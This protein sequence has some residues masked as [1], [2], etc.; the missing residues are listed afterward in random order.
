MSA[1]NLE[2]LAREQNLVSKDEPFDVFEAKQNYTQKVKLAGEGPRVCLRCHEMRLNNADERVPYVN[3]M[4]EAHNL[5]EDVRQY[6]QE[7]LDVISTEADTA[8]VYLTCSI[9]EFPANVPVFLRKRRNLK[10]VLTKAEGVVYVPQV[11]SVNVQMWAAAQMQ[12]L[13]F[14]MAAENV[15][16]F[17]AEH[18]K[19]G[20]LHQFSMYD[21][22]RGKN[23]YIVGFPNTGKTSLFNVLTEGKFSKEANDLR[24]SLPKDRR[25][26]QKWKN[27]SWHPE[28][29]LKPCTKKTPFG[30]ITD[31]PAFKRANSPWN[32]V[33]PTNNSYL[34]D[35]MILT[36]NARKFAGVDVHIKRNQVALVSGLFG[37]ESTPASELLVWTSIPGKMG[38]A[39]H[40]NA[41]KANIVCQKG[42]GHDRA[43]YNL[44]DMG[45]KDLPE[46]VELGTVTFDQDDGVGV[47]VAFEGAGFARIK[48]TG[49]KENK[50]KAVIWGFPGQVFA[51]RQPL[52]EL[53]LNNEA[54]VKGFFGLKDPNWKHNRRPIFNYKIDF[55]P[56]R[57]VDQIGGSDSYLYRVKEGSQAHFS[58]EQLMRA[59][60]ADPQKTQAFKLE[61]KL[62]LNNRPRP[63]DGEDSF[64]TPEDLET[65][66]EAREKIR[67]KKGTSK[68]GDKK[69]QGLIWTKVGSSKNIKSWKW[70]TPTEAIKHAHKQDPDCMWFKQ[71]HGDK[72]FH[73]VI[74]ENLRRGR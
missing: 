42:Q 3:S 52:C 8:T 41:A 63:A 58:P 19:S 28:Q 46:L 30:K 40:T 18:D 34:T 56:T 64:L 6:N 4:S 71:K 68:K 24:Y 7:I 15:H 10:L 74:E 55:E 49:A 13:G 50:P 62:K 54:T 44:L 27:T 35:K 69:K 61:R 11:N 67:A 20:G 51:F 22:Q 23:V 16:F 29:T 17:S 1:E 26:L 43:Q 39:K 38:L 66:D 31:M 59:K 47:E 72:T 12:S 2:F 65:M 32:L 5:K 48:R 33:N 37:V 45:K 25:V 9:H 36:D 21:L 53:M 57:N 73:Q 60:R 70:L 14:K